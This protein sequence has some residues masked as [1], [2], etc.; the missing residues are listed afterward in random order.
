MS[1]IYSFD[2][3]SDLEGLLADRALTVGNTSGIQKFTRI[4][5]VASDI[6][7]VKRV[8]DLIADREIEEGKES[9]LIL[10]PNCIRALIH[11]LTPISRQLESDEAKFFH[12]KELWEKETIMLSSVTTISMHPAYQKIIG[13]GSKALPLIFQEM[14]KKPGHWFWA[15]KSITGIDPVPLNLRGRL[16]QMTDIWLSWGK[17]KGYIE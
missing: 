16:K 5:V 11:Y 2:R 6:Q 13:M 10:E 7:N 12:L 9:F 8:E 1:G 15:L 4:R 17:E 14:K 3:D